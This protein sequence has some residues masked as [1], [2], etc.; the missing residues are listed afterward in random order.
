L[1]IL[2]PD[3]PVPGAPGD[4]T[5]THWLVWNLPVQNAT[6]MLAESAVPA[7]ARQGA[8]S[9]GNDSYAPMCPPVGSPPHHYHFL[10][11]ALPAPLDL[12]P[13]ASQEEFQSAV[14]SHALANG[15]MVG[16]YVR[17]LPVD[18]SRGGG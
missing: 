5:F 12:M 4:S 6:A 8:N 17:A 11:F 2:D 15:S 3:V 1:E 16:L 14:A 9:A 10:A 18:A 13:G 7:E